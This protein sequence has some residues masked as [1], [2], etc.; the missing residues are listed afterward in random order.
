MANK[1]N[2]ASQALAPTEAQDPMGLYDTTP[3]LILPVEK[4]EQKYND[5]I[6]QTASDL[7][8]IFERHSNQTFVISVEKTAAFPFPYWLRPTDHNELGTK[9]A[10]KISE[11][12]HSISSANMAF[13]KA[14][15]ITSFDRNVSYDTAGKQGVI[16]VEPRLRR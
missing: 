15:Q 9:I 16:T 5:R 7:I 8:D 11:D 13:Q 1:G 14:L 6:A 3:R 2:I 12:G 10:D 4:A